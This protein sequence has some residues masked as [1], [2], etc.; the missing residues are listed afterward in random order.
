[1]RTLGEARMVSDE[2]W[3]AVGRG[4]GVCWEVGE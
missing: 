2:V 3:W 1:M 4:I